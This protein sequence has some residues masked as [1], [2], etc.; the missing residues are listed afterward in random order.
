MRR[1]ANSNSVTIAAAAVITGTALSAENLVGGKIF[2]W[3]DQAFGHVRE[4]P[5]GRF[6]KVV[7]GVNHGAALKVS[8]DVVC[9][10]RIGTWDGNLPMEA[11]PGLMLQDICSGNAHLVGLTP[12]QE[13]R[14]WGDPNYGLPSVPAGLFQRVSAGMHHCAALRNDGRVLCWGYNGYGQCDAPVEVFQDITCASMVTVALRSDGSV[15]RWG[16]D[17]GAW[18][19]AAPEVV[20]SALAQSSWSSGQVSGWDSSGRWYSWDVNGR[21]NECQIQNAP[22]ATTSLQTISLTVNGGAAIDSD[23]LLRT[24]GKSPASGEYAGRRFQQLSAGWTSV[25]AIRAAC[26]ADL[27]NSDVVDS[28]DL[29]LALLDF[30]ACDACNADL[31]QNG[32]VDSG[33]V[34][35]MLLDFGRCP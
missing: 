21:C 30:G 26:P 12:A 19:T 23:G 2:M 9:W 3:G 34:A 10:G 18:G 17:Y 32:E 31:D 35:L 22:P 25:A 13:I 5:T 4:F 11:P 7:V 15:A 28:G 1:F 20:L 33:D 16:E 24:W 8:G 29:A 6:K 14:L 27:D